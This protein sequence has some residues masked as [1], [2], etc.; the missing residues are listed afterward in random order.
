MKENNN[1]NI[2]NESASIMKII[3]KKRKK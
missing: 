2:N 1:E 3:E